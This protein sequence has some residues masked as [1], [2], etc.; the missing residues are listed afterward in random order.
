MEFEFGAP[1]TIMPPADRA[2]EMARRA[3]ADGYESI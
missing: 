2:I 1:G 3:E